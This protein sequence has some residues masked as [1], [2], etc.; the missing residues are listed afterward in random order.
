MPFFSVVIPLYNKQDYISQSLHS[1]LNQ[2]FK[3][4]EVII[5][6][7]GSTDRSQQ[8]IESFQ[9]SRIRL[10]N[11]KNQGVSIA[12]NTAVA[13]STGKIIAFLDA[14]DIWYPTHLEEIYH[15]S[16]KFPEA[17]LFATAYEIEYLSSFVQKYIL[18]TPKKTSLLFPFYKYVKGSPLFYTSN[19]ALKTEVF[20]QED[21]FKASIHAEDT[22]LFLRLGYKYPLAYSS[23]ISMR[24]LDQT[25]NSLFAKYNTDM[26]VKML[27]ELAELEKK[28]KFLKKILDINRFSWAIEYKMK[29]QKNKFYALKKE[30]DRKNLNF[31]QQVMLDSPR[32]VLSILKSI[33]NQLLKRKIYLTPYKKSTNL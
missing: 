4:F 14:D 3:D 18:E 21:G 11:Q 29:G 16:K 7:D 32:A 20:L 28:D 30:I 27:E 19:F 17:T 9:D 31:I 33:Q 2:Q 12:R 6:N 13:K 5:I 25:V 8:I 1:V 23:M 15:L 22:E 26:K 24:H 10:F